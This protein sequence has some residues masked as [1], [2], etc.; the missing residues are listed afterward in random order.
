[1][2]SS[3]ALRQLN[4]LPWIRQSRGKTFCSSIFVCQR[5]CSLLPAKEFTKT[6]PMLLLSQALKEHTSAES[7]DRAE[8][9]YVVTRDVFDEYCRASHVKDCEEALK[10]LHESGTVVSMSGG[11]AVQLRPAQLLWACDDMNDTG[12]SQHILQEAGKR[13]EEAVAEEQA[14]RRLLQPAVLRASRWRRCVWASVLCFVAAELAIIS[15]LTF[16]DFNWDVMEPITYFLGSG[17]S[18]LFF[19]YFLRYGYPL[20]CTGH[21]QRMA[22]ARVKRYA[23]KSFDW[24]KYEELCRRVEEEQYMM[25]KIKKW[26]NEH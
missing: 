23:P 12:S 20:T 7:G 8:G 4:T 1:M 9:R 25:G 22:A 19:V 24:G 5:R 14:M 16:F 18:L 6:A 10:L 11:K 2:R 26:F 17:T 13:L 15:R 21:D 3:Y